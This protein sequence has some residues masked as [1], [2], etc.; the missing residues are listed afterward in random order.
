MLLLEMILM[1]KNEANI[2]GEEEYL[3]LFQVRWCA[4]T[5]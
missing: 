4:S 2:D 1:A 3:A 5:S